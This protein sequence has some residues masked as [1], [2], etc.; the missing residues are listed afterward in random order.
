MIYKDTTKSNYSPKVSIIIN[1]FNGEKFLKE[2]IES[3]L[4]QTYKNWELIFFDNGSTDLSYK[5]F[6]SFKDSR[7]NYFSS[8]ENTTLAIAR[9]S[10]IQ[11]CKGDLIAFLDVDDYWLQEKLELQVQE[12]KKKE[13]GLCCS[14]YYLIN[15]RRKESVKKKISFKDRSFNQDSTNDLLKDYFI[16]ISTLIFRKDVL[17]NLGYIFDNRF[18]IIEDF[19]FVVRLSLFT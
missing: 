10:A 17:V 8:K 5:I 9:N 2:S 18:S 19:D 7:F 14:G 6:S 12:F 3:I 11:K 16:H 15:E 4:S 13:V 1:C